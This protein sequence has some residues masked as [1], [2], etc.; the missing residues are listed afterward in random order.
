[1]PHVTVKMHSGRPAQQKAR[2]A[3]EI[4]KAVMNALGCSADSVSVAIEDVEPGEWF[5]RV[6]DPEIGARPELLY[7]KPGYPRP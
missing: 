5:T 2:L 3:E 7:K 1:M 6:Y 4:T